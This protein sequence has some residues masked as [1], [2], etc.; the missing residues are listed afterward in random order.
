MIATGVHERNT[1]CPGCGQ[2]GSVIALTDLVYTFEVCHCHD[3][4]D[5]HLV[6]TLWHKSCYCDKCVKEMERERQPSE[7][8]R[9]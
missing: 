1:I 2:D 4:Q 6:E 5:G 7:L 3:D 9:S 8:P